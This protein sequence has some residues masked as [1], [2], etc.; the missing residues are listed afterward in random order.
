MNSSAQQQN[1][2]AALRSLRFGLNRLRD[3]GL[4]LFIV[5]FA[6]FAGLVEPQFWSQSNIVNLC[7]QIAPLLIISVGQAL[8][9]ISGGLDLSLAAVLALSGVVGV[10]VMNEYGVIAGL[11][12][13]VFTGAVFGTLNGLIIAR[14]KVS[15]LIVTLGMLSVCKGIAM[16]VSGGLPI[17]NM[18]DIYLDIVGDGTVLGIPASIIIAAGVVLAAA[19]ILG[20][21]KLGRYVYAIGSNEEAAFSS[22]IDVK[23]YLVIVYCL[24]GITAGIG[25]IVLTA[26]VN[27][28]QPTAAAGLEL[29]SIAAVVLGGVALTGGRG[30]MRN[31]VYGAVIL[32][33]LTN[34]LNMIGVSS[35]MQTVVIGVVIIFAVILD[36]MRQGAR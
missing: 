11:L 1:D 16:M 33:M 36:R 9:I 21:T 31:V 19:V 29:T 3:Y 2:S 34:A 24:S 17:Y 20:Y 15:P 28:A 27:A 7:R 26:W 10:M 25:A 23:K 12:A 22:G 30:Y 35:F 18:P 6:L 32:G 5:A 14:F 13:M 8:A 4:P